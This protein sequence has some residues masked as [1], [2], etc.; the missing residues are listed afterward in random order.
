MLHT[1]C[2]K[3]CTFLPGLYAFPKF[4]HLVRQFFFSL[5]ST[6]LHFSPYSPNL[7]VLISVTK[8]LDSKKCEIEF[9]LITDTIDAMRRIY[10]L[11]IIGKLTQNYGLLGSKIKRDI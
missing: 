4:T 5:Q 6:S 2:Q 3:I 1:N 11:R 8:F 10:A 9:K 7:E